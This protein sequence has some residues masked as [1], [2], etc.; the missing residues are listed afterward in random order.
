[1]CLV[2]N[3]KNIVFSSLEESSYLVIS[4]METVDFLQ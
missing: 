2:L 1:L 4:M 3:F